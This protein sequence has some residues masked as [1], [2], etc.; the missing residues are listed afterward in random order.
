MKSA[1]VQL[2]VWGVAEILLGIL[3]VLYFSLFPRA[4]DSDFV[5]CTVLCLLLYKGA[6][7]LG[8]KPPKVEAWGWIDYAFLIMFLSFYITAW[9][10]GCVSGRCSV[11]AVLDSIII[12]ITYLYYGFIQHYLAQRYLAVKM[13]SLSNHNKILAALLTGLAFGFLHIRELQLIIP[14]AFGGALFALYYLYTGRLWMVVLA[15][16]MISSTLIFWFFGRNPFRSI[17][18]WFA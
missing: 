1:K 14:S 3:V 9:S 4:A 12:T 13:L 18:A 17:V 15:H 5:V 8:L 6:P 11:D 7:K 2:T 10:Y 16:A